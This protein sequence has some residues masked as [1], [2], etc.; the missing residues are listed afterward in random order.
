M[1]IS[2]KDQF[3]GFLSTPQIFAENSIFGYPSFNTLENCSKAL[4]FEPIDPP[5]KVLGKRMEDFFAQ[6]VINFTPEEILVRNEQ[7]IEGKNTV[8]EIDFLLRH[9]AS[10]IVSHVEMI[11]KFYLFDPESGTSELD[12]FIGPNKRDS[13]NRKLERLQKRQFP[14]LFH[15][16]TKKLLNSLELHAEDVVQKICFKAAVFLPLFMKEHVPTQI[17][18]ETL[19]GYWIKAKEF[20]PEAYGEN[21]FFIPGKFYWPVDPRVNEV[22]KP[23]QIIE[24]ELQVLL[25]K[26]F[27]PL[28]WMKTP[29]GNHERLFIVWW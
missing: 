2:V 6:Y 13:L 27:A 16:A 18:P 5:A 29:A 10:E 17:N 23:F 24:E 4:D 11:F 20:T 14:L 8:G 1:A 9:P 7:I 28:I 12:H 15:S 25:K 22:W 26:R 19:T 21:L 3:K